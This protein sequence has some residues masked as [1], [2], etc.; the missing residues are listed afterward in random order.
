MSIFLLSSAHIVI[1]DPH[2]EDSSALGPSSLGSFLL[3]RIEADLRLVDFFKSCR[4][5]SS[6]EFRD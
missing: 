4:H 1:L 3:V 6:L 5:L 2:L